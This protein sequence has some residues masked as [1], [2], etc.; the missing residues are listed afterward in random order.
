MML[1]VL[2]RAS[3][4]G[5]IVAALIWTVIRWLPRL[6]PATRA[7]LWWC[8][9]AKFLLALLWMSPVEFP[10]L[11]AWA[12][13]PAA[14][15]R[16]PAPAASTATVPDM[17][18]PSA[19]AVGAPA[20]DRGIDWPI[21]LLVLWS[22][23]LVTGAGIDLRRLVGTRRVM[24]RSSPA[25][26]QTAAA[27]AALASA[28]GLR[29]TPAV[30]LSSETTTPLVVGVLRPRILLPG[31]GAASL[32]E[33]EERMALCHELSHVKR[34][35]LWL[36][37]VPAAAE[38]LFFFHP[39]V[40][41]ASREY[42]L[43]REAACDAAVI[44]TLATSPQDYGRLLLSL[45]VSRNH[46]G[47]AVAGASSSCSML[48]RRIAMLRDSSPSTPGRRVLSFLMIAAAVT[49]VVPLRLTAR[50][51]A[52]D[53][54]QSRAT[55]DR[56]PAWADADLSRIWFGPG[57]A[58]L[59]G[60]THDGLALPT[61]P[62]QQ[63][64][65]GHLYVGTGKRDLN[66]V[67]LIDNHNANVSGSLADI[68][69]ARSLRR[70]GE[71]LL[72]IRRNGAEHV[73]RDA[74]V[75]EQVLQIWRPVNDLGDAQ[76]ALGGKQGALGTQQGALGAQQGAFGMQQGVL[77]TRQAEVAVRQA[78]LA[79]REQNAST[80]AE[81]Q[82]L[83]ES[84]RQLDAEA[85]VLE[86]QMR[87][88][89]LKMREL[90]QPMRDLDR[91]MRALGAQME[92]LGRE[93]EEASRRAERQMLE[94]IDRVIAGGLAERVAVS[95][96]ELQSS[97]VWS[98]LDRLSRLERLGRLGRLSRLSRLERMM[99]R[100]ETRFNTA[101]NRA[102]SR[103]NNLENRLNSR[104]NHFSSRLAEVARLNGPAL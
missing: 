18:V 101:L 90:D 7:A 6:P 82:A 104:L 50:A 66:Y 24:R 2:I 89:D 103:L 16:P 35:D 29:R 48:K 45:G 19:A 57:R 93:M 61:D 64:A 30:R 71:P 32:S 52:P 96:Q 51:Q 58:W 11:P 34:A 53:L 49:A 26:E 41:L 102:S 43:C 69:R 13:A 22:A 21:V 40:R 14:R 36:G 75:I 72:W 25:S 79:G 8:A 42:L 3:L 91:E 98:R 46:A 33:D 100:L 4:E 60:F 63:E 76:G 55:A 70:G 78:A 68:D 56:A 77:G 5:A 99:T 80:A 23:G 73:V 86:A 87:A 31:N 10:V 17:P 44:D 67:L 39:L 62:R 95:R 27:A 88:L 12:E 38:R 85:R 94:L 74:K 81:R 92:T 28:I 97:S 65:R 59:G 83:D 47:L 9:A 84:R 15:L 37:L 54:E 1:A 20:D